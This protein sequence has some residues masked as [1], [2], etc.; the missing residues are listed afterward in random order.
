MPP[1][2]ERKKEEEKNRSFEEPSRNFYGALA[3]EWGP[4]RQKEKPFLIQD[5]AGDKNPHLP[6]Q[7]LRYVPLVAPPPS[8]L[9]LL[10]ARISFRYQDY[11]YDVCD[12]IVSSCALFCSYSTISLSF[13]SQNS[14]D[15]FHKT[16]DWSLG[17]W[18]VGSHVVRSSVSARR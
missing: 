4:L 13:T 9:E 15:V 7:K 16:S 3:A 5:G 1:H 6:D 12:E 8:L 2:K 17:R 18:P 10:S 14:G 11:D